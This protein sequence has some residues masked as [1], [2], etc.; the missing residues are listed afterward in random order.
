MENTACSGNSPLH[1][2]EQ[3]V[4]GCS[5]KPSSGDLVREGGGRKGEGHRGSIPVYTG[6]INGKLQE[7]G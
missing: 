3:A 1:Q 7:K 4:S 6:G 5:F 2:R